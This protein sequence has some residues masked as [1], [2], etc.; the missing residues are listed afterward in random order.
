MANGLLD[1][2]G[3]AFG[4][5]PP[6]YMQGLLGADAV[7]NLRKRS[8]GSGLVNALI[9]YAAAPKNQN[10]GLGRILAGAAQSGIQGAQGVYQN[11]TQDYMTQEKIAEMQRQKDKQTRLQTMLGGITDPNERMLAELNPDAYVTGKL[12]P[13]NS[14]DPYYTPIATEGGL[15]S[16][17]N[18]TGLFNSLDINGVPIIKSTDSPLVR[19]S[20]K[21]AEAIAT[22]EQKPNIMVDG[23]VLT[24]AQVAEMARKG[25]PLKFYTPPTQSGGT[26]SPQMQIPPAVQN[27][28]D[29]TRMA[30]LLNEQAAGGGVGAN[31]ELDKE[32][33]NAQR[34]GTQYA[35]IRVPTDAEKEQTKANIQVAAETEK[36]RLSN[37]EKDKVLVNSRKDALSSITRTKQ[38]LEAGIYTGAYANITKAG[39][40]YTPFIDKQRAV[41][42]ET[43]LS[44]IG[45]T[46][47]PR[48]QEFGGNDSNEEMKYL[49][50]IMGGDI[51]IE[52][53]ALKNILD[54]SEKKIRRGIDRHN[55]GLDSDGKANASTDTQI[56]YKSMAQQELARRKGKK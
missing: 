37:I 54:S 1:L 17:N 30:I 43:F 4:T 29:N 28:R 25:S 50:A 36:T 8:I 23:S 2:L 18:R 39:A 40:K 7:E 31:P 26:P 16:F 35:G 42:T 27:Q 21:S 33:G 19:G 56:D 9:G 47:V 38:L 15:G 14:A 52:K 55:K 49:R 5:S 20:V 45:N 13:A 53:G 32:I 41:N 46:V 12:K 51:T 34:S 11:A 22:A 10:L 6:E 24:D 48:L 44:E 3:G